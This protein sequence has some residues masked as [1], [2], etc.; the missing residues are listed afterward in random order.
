MCSG[1]KKGSLS[2]VE[3]S[4][5][6]QLIRGRIVREMTYNLLT[7][8]QGESQSDYVTPQWMEKLVC[9]REVT[10]RIKAESSLKQLMVVNQVIVKRGCGRE[11]RRLG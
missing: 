11:K 10:E 3:V 2:P 1:G 7:C 6:N 5:K 9:H 8:T 4:L